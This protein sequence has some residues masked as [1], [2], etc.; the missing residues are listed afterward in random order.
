MNKV[1]FAVAYVAC[2]CHGRRVQALSRRFQ[3]ESHLDNLKGL[4]SLATLLNIDPAVAFNFANTRPRSLVRDSFAISR[5]SLE[6]VQSSITLVGPA[7]GLQETEQSAVDADNEELDFKAAAA[8]ASSHTHRELDFAAGLET[9][10]A[11]HAAERAA[12]LAQG[13]ALAESKVPL[14]LPVQ[15]HRVPREVLGMGAHCPF[16]NDELIFACPEMFAESECRALRE[17]AAKII[18]AEDPV[19]DTDV[20]VHENGEVPLQ[21]M[22]RAR[23]WL[24]SVA[25]ARIA[26]LAASCFPSAVDDATSLWIHG[27]Y[28]VRY[29]ATA[30]LSHQPIHRDPSLISCVIPLNEQHEYEGGGTYFEPLERS[31]TLERGSALLHPSAVRH[32]GHRISSGERWVL[33]LF[34]NSAT[35]PYGEHGRRF[36]ARAHSHR[37]DSDHEV[38]GEYPG[39]KDLV[40]R[41]LLHAARL[42]GENNHEAWFDLGLHAQ[43]RGDVA[44]AFHLYQKAEE[45]NPKDAMLLGNMGLACLDLQRRE[46]AFEYYH[47]AFNADHAKGTIFNG[48]PLKLM[49]RSAFR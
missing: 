5:S 32:A 31:I 24:N 1:A 20:K 22:P 37:P 45:I 30:S 21:M 12:S 4:K 48:K 2:T 36:R 39:Q 18:D 46:D 34:L 28:V 19:S 26:S 25:F 7:K 49:Q 42:T 40:L 16:D 6:A 8:A 10:L 33:V 3:G 43:Q 44:R 15:S 27:G 14:D 38:D 17:E 13:Y 41:E 11:E 9:N 29:D 35:M 47:N 23:H